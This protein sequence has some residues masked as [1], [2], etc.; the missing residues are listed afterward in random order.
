M[1]F[2]DAPGNGETR[3]HS[4]QIASVFGS[5]KTLEEPGQVGLID[6]YSVSA[7]VIATCGTPFSLI[8]LFE[9]AFRHSAVDRV[10]SSIE[11][12]AAIRH[13]PRCFRSMLLVFQ[14]ID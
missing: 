12:G 6:A 11:E 8:P 2:N 1:L 9:V 10:L 4:W 13:S 3:F 14:L 7:M 5:I